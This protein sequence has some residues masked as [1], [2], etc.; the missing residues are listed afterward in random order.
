MMPG[1]VYRCYDDTGRLLYV[2]STM[3]TANQRLSNHRYLNR[4]HGK[5]P[6]VSDVAH[7]ATDEYQSWQEALVAEAAL[8][9]ALRPL[10]NKQRTS[11]ES[12]RGCLAFSV[13]DDG[14]DWLLAPVGAAL[15][16]VSA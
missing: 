1:I 5:S 6:W 14:I 11:V 15:A 3:G 10:G 9:L 16:G 7:V 4:V 13:A 12:V 2:G 8:I